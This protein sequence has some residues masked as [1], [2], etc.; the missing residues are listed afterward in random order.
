LPIVPDRGTKTVEDGDYYRMRITTALRLSGYN[1]S[2]AP[3]GF[4]QATAKLRDDT[5][6]YDLVIV[7]SEIAPKKGKPPAQEETV[8][9]LDYLQ[10]GHPKVGIII[11]LTPEYALMPI[12]SLDE[13]LQLPNV[14][15]VRK[16]Y[17]IPTDP[18]DSNELFRA[19]KH[20]LES[21]RGG[22][23]G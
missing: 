16:P 10:K 13:K 8:A 22:A 3:E 9:L 18:R 19:I 11:S 7:G 4:A 12:K 6:T 14:G 1:V 17:E 5:S 15:I 20:Q 21:A 2:E 23:R